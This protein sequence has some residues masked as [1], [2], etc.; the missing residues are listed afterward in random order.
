MSLPEDVG[1]EPVWGLFPDLLTETEST[2]AGPPLRVLGVNE[3]D[4]LTANEPTQTDESRALHS[5]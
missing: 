2:A 4:A 3:I 1:Q 5:R